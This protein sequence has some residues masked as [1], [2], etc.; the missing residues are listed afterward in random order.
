MQEERRDGGATTL[1]GV[2]RAHRLLEQGFPFGGGV[3]RVFEPRSV[4]FTGFFVDNIL[5]RRSSVVNSFL[6]FFK[7]S[8]LS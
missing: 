5:N 8:S 3:F 7:S 6:E 4:L 1:P 2:V